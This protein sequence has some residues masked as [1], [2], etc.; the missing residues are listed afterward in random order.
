MLPIGGL[1]Y[2]LDDFPYEDIEGVH[3]G[4][5]YHNGQYEVVNTKPT[6]GEFQRIL[7]EN[8]PAIWNNA[9]K[10]EP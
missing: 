8:H 5:K 7:E 3:H 2:N 10:V 1:N 9:E 6:I 4:Y